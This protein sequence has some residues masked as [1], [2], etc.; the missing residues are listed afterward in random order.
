MND[1]AKAQYATPTPTCISCVP[2]HRQLPYTG[3]DLFPVFVLGVSLLV[4]GVVILTALR[5]R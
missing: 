4:L 3:V 1:A 2:P 5:S